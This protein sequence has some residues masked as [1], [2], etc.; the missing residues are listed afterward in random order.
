MMPGEEFSF[1]SYCEVEVENKPKKVKGVD[2]QAFGI[3]YMKSKCPRKAICSSHHV[4][5]TTIG[6]LLTCSDTWLKS[7]QLN[8]NVQALLSTYP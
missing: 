6:L 5:G 4:R 3:Q 8:A 7:D 1:I 2:N